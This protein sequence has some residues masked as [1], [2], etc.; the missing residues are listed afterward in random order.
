MTR[1]PAKEIRA[2]A[3]AHRADTAVVAKEATGRGFDMSFP[4]SRKATL[5]GAA[6][7]G[8]GMAAGGMVF[9]AFLDRPFPIRRVGI[10]AAAFY[11]FLGQTAGPPEERRRRRELR[12]EARREMRRRG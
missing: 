9:S 11:A 5:M 7:V 2:S 8:F 3:A 10:S 1:S 6:G 4:R 12:R